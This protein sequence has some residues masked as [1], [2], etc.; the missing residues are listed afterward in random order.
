MKAKSKELVGASTAVLILGVLRREPN[1]GYEIVR[2]LNIEADEAFS[3]QE[4][5]IYPVLHKLER[6]GLVRCRWREAPT[7]RKRKYYTITSKGRDALD[8]G[9]HQ[10]RVF[11]DLIIRIAGASHARATS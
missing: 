10:W 3:W 6:R 1:Y 2:L 7:G 4:G 9:T 8:A 5:T 11:H